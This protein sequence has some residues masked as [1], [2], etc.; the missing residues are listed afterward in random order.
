[1]YKDLEKDL[2]YALRELVMKIIEVAKT[3]HLVYII[4]IIY[5]Y[6]YIYLYV[7]ENFT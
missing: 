4:Y 1:M 6:I 2:Y 7:W 3:V 5:I